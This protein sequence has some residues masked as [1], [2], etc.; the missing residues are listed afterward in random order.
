LVNMF[1]ILSPQE[2]RHKHRNLATYQNKKNPND[3]HQIKEQLG[4]PLPIHIPS[5]LN[6][7][8]I[9]FSVYAHM[10]LETF[11]KKIENWRL[12]FEKKRIEERAVAVMQATHG[13]L[14]T[15]DKCYIEIFPV[16]YLM[17]V[18]LFEESV[19]GTFHIITLL[20]LILPVVLMLLDLRS[21]INM[22]DADREILLNILDYDTVL[23]EPTQPSLEGHMGIIFDLAFKK[24]TREIRITFLFVIHDFN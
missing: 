3:I 5:D 21:Y 7:L 19:T 9:Y 24:H 4:A 23:I 20:I 8:G 15:I 12:G 6:N 11:N 2:T 1:I 16:N 10:Y 22:D 17:N 13:I 18:L 14:F